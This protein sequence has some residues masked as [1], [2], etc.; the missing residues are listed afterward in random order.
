MLPDEVLVEI[1]DHYRLVSPDNPLF[2]TWGW[3]KL[4]HVCKRWR[5][6]I[7]GSPHRL[8]VRLVYT[9]VYKYR[10]PVKESLDY[11]PD[12]PLSIRYPGLG[13]YQ[14]LSRA[15]E[16]NVIAA[17]K[18]PD[19]ICEIN[20]TLTCPLFK[21]LT[22]LMQ[23]PFP[24]LE[25]LELGSRDLDDSLVLPSTFLGGSTP[26]LR[27]INLDG[28]PFPT[29]PQ[30]IVTA[31]DLVL[32]R[33]SG[34]PYTGYFSPEALVKGLDSAPK[35]KVLEIGWSTSGPGQRSPRAPYP[36]T[37]VALSALTK[38]QFRGDSEY[39]EDLIARIDAPNVEHFDATLF[40][41]DTL[42]LPQLAEFIG[43][44]KNLVRSPYRTS[45]SSWDRGFS[46]TYYF[47]LPFFAGPQTFQLQILFHELAQQMKLLIHVCRQL[48][49]LLSKVGLL[50]IEADTL[51]LDW[52]DQKDAAQWLE[53][54]S[55]FGG[56][57]RLGLIGHVTRSA[58]LAL[59]QSASNIDMGRWEVLPSLRELHLRGFDPSPPME[60][61][62]AARRRSGSIV[63]IYYE[64]LSKHYYQ[65][66][67]ES[68]HLAKVVTHS[69]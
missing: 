53:L 11:W 1:F 14:P 66:G 38:F 56:V 9:Y 69:H 59:E 27:Y 50:D 33:L 22:S 17:L 65:R 35:L 21:K 2:G 30:L 61:F 51:L 8:E 16:E 58:A 54:F 29:L 46:I 57:R 39:L 6:V 67:S 60:S 3:Y 12:L 42:D 64:L 34:I 4:T 24:M 45:I 19:R 52:Q 32:I 31:R 15:D 40:E 36:Q 48:S 37:R 10:K 63:S 23:D 41:Q 7:F 25:D 47:E 20:V 44:T 68:N 26:R 62:L 43:R 49:P 5:A 55:P 28:T 18:Y 13:L